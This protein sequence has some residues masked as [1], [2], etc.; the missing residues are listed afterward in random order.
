MLGLTLRWNRGH[1]LHGSHRAE[2]EIE[3]LATIDQLM[4]KLL[5]KT[6]VN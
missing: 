2:V 3:S 6:R 4:Q 5:G 1:A